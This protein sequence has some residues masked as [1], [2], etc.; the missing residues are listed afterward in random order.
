MGFRVF[1]LSFH[2]IFLTPSSPLH[3]L[4][5][6]LLMLK[7]GKK[8]RERERRRRGGR[9]GRRRRKGQKNE[10]RKVGREKGKKRKER[11]IDQA[12]L[13]FQFSYQH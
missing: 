9:E 2:L 12:I 11:T 6:H 3:L 13:F 8:E 7:E 1:S 4:G 5:I 10:G